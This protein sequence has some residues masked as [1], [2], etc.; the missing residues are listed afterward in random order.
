[1]KSVHLSPRQEQVVRLIS[2]GRTDRQIAA[3]LGIDYSTVRVHVRLV[4]VR[5]HATNRAEAAF[6]WA[7]R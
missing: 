6:K 3:L 7:N 4:F 1:M 5:L 2:R